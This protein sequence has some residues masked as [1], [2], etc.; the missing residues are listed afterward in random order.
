MPSLHS[1]FTLTLMNY[2]LANFKCIVSKFIAGAKQIVVSFYLA[3]VFQ[4]IL[5]LVIGL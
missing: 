3:N 5:N 1:N 4:N 2:L